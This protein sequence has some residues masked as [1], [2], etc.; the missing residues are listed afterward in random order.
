MALELT[1]ILRLHDKMTAPLRRATQQMS[2][3]ERATDHAERPVSRMRGVAAGA[4][5]AF[6]SMGTSAGNALTSIASKAVK[7]SASIAGIG[8]AAAAA[9]IVVGSKSALK[10]ASDAEQ[11]G[12]AFE[13]MIGDA[14]RAQTFIAEMT[15]FAAKT[16]FDL[17]GVRDAAKRMLAFGFELDRVLPMLTAVGNAASGLGLGSDGIGRITLALGQM[18][19]KAKVSADEMLQL[20]EAGIPAWQMLADKMKISTGEVMKLAEKGLI[21]ADAAINTLIDGMNKK[22]PN[23]MEKQSKSLQGLYNNMKEV[24]ENKLMLKWGEGLAS[25]LKPRF[26]QVVKWIDNNEAAIDR[27]GKRLQNAAS[28]GADWIIRKFEGA[29]S[30]VRGLM[31]NPEF[32]KINTISGKVKFVIDDLK[33]MYDEW[34][35]TGGKQQ[36]EEMSRSVTGFL[37][38]T[39]GAAAKPLL[40]AGIELGKSVGEGMLSGLKAFAKEHPLLAAGMTFVATPGPLPVKAMAASGVLAQTTTTNTYEKAK[41]AGFFNPGVNLIKW[42]GDNKIGEGAADSLIFSPKLWAER[43]KTGQFIPPSRESGG[44]HAGGLSRVPYNGY[45]AILHKDE[46]VLTASDAETRRNSGNASGKQTN[47]TVNLTY[48]GRGRSSREEV[49]ELA[50]LLADELEALVR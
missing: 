30:Y 33:R 23:M 19:A 21:P 40:D 17:P 2:S 39:L 11:A 46:A 49:L 26:E 29:F 34:F 15:D 42:M 10:L 28:T 16:P 45:R 9:G 25:A 13:T 1:A 14:A 44:S 43:I 7:T 48:N 32:A 18:K 3:L 20:T 12:I 5:A 47:V 37:G 50:G 38:K 36:I 31:N 24:F 27:W 6:V 4:G 22:F 41:D 8:T 35:A